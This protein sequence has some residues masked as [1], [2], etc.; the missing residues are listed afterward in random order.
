MKPPSK[1][2]A[3]QI[4]MMPKYANPDGNIFGGIILSYIDQAGAIEA[5]RQSPHKYVTVCMK[6]VAF[7]QPVYIGDI[8]SIWAET[9]EI[10]T[11]SITIQVEVYATH[12][13]RSGNQKVHVTTATVVYVALD[14]T[15]K[16]M[17]ITKAEDE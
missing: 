16:P 3:I 6:E 8:L 11:T 12:T 14:R 17:P 9:K 13:D 15:G 5:M 10:G 2:P 1:T 4:M 7:K